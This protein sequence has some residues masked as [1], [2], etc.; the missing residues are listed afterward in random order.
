M[1]KLKVYIEFDWWFLWVMLGQIKSQQWVCEGEGKGKARQHITNIDQLIISPVK[2]T[3]IISCPNLTYQ[4]KH[5]HKHIQDTRKWQAAFWKELTAVIVHS[6]HL[7]FY[8]Y[9]DKLFYIR[10]EKRNTE[11]WEFTQSQTFAK[12]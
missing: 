3:Y 5:T 7:I 1:Y 11:I 9:F 6:F 12:N 2:I 4:N 10:H 8:I